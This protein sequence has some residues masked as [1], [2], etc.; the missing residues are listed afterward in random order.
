[1][2]FTITT[3]DEEADDIG[4]VLERINREKGRPPR[5]GMEHLKLMKGHNGG[6]SYPQA[7]DD[8]TMHTQNEIPLGGQLIEYE[9]LLSEEKCVAIGEACKRADSAAVKSLLGISRLSGTKKYIGVDLAFNCQ[10]RQAAQVFMQALP[11][12]LESLDLNLKGNHLMIP[13][14]SVVADG[15]PKALKHLQ[16]EL[17]HN[18]LQVQGVEI[19]M[20]AI[21]TTVTRLTVGC[22]GMR[23]GL[24]GV[25]ALAD[26]LPPKLTDLTLDLHD[27]LMGDDGCIHLSQHLP[28]TL[29]KLNIHMQGDQAL[30]TNRGYWIFDRLIGDAKNPHALP[31]LI[32]ENFRCVRNDTRECVQQY[33]VTEK[34]WELVQRWGPHENVC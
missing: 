33:E 11:A 5:P 6:R 19:F 29:E 27:G 14:I 10:G 18:K 16:V 31:K 8:P 1:M 2:V 17:S 23:M 30:L 34:E 26:N 13:G 9:D 22:G 32:R 21:P 7:W 12:G 3:T 24:P 25:R 28:K 20:K 15:L 4:P